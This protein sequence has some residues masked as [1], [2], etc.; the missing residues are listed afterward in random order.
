MN[1]PYKA[2]I[3]QK[4]GYCSSY[5]VLAAVSMP[6]VS[7]YHPGGYPALSVFLSVVDS[8]ES[9]TESGTQ[10]GPPPVRD[11]GMCLNVLGGLLFWMSSHFFWIS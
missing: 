3:A 11:V 2:T 7:N 4:T 10:P 5:F 1:Y 6:T 9:G 8:S